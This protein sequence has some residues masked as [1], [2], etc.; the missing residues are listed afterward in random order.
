MYISIG[1]AFIVEGK[2]D[3]EIDIW[4]TW[5]QLFFFKLYKLFS[6]WNQ[7]FPNLKKNILQDY[8]ASPAPF[9]M[10]SFTFSKFD[11]KERI[12]NCAGVGW[13]INPFMPT[14]PTFAVRETDVYRTANVGTVGKNWLTDVDHRRGN[15]LIKYEMFQTIFA[16]L[17]NWPYYTGILTEMASYSCPKYLCKCLYYDCNGWSKHVMFFVAVIYLCNNVKSYFCDSD[18]PFFLPF[19]R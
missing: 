12:L 10:P 1:S 18:C 16:L 2:N 5:N 6:T 13:C 7:L 11:M 17:L 14:V 9:L 4:Q 3:F 19:Q 8:P 15:I